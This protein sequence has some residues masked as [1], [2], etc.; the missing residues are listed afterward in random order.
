MLRPGLSGSSITV[1]GAGEAT[2]GING[3]GIS[4]SICEISTSSSAE[5]LTAANC[6][7]DKREPRSFPGFLGWGLR[8]DELPCGRGDRYERSARV[9]KPL[10]L[11]GVVGSSLSDLFRGTLIRGIAGVGADGEVA[12]PSMNSTSMLSWLSSSV[13]GVKGVLRETDALSELLAVVS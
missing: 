3:A 8:E 11:V 10:D 12:A 7:Q 9:G 5:L 2:P 13:C 4:E 6:S 1:L